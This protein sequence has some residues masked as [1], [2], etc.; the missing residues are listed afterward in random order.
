[1]SGTDRP[2]DL[3]PGLAVPCPDCPPA[4]GATSPSV[5]AATE[6][7]RFAS[8]LLSAQGCPARGFRAPAASRCL[9]RRGLLGT[10][11]FSRWMSRSDLAVGA[12][13][14]PLHPLGGKDRAVETGISGRCWL[15]LSLGAFK[16][17]AAA[18]YSWRPHSTAAVG[19]G[20]VAYRAGGRSAL[21]HCRAR[22]WR[23]R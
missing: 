10:T 5:S 13:R 22:G 9:V 11:N 2:T 6:N 12:G 4:P 15:R 23:G 16:T 17:R 19:L 1:M 14:E 8:E 18:V 7:S 3:V 20:Q 21:C